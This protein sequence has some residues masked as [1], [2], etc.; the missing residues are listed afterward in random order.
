[1]RLPRIVFF[2]FLLVL[3]AWAAQP[4]VL[5]LEQALA[6][7][8]GVNSNVLLSREAAAQAL[9]QANLARAGVLPNIALN[10][11]QRRSRNLNILSTTGALSETRPSNRFDGRLA[12]TLSLLNP[13]QLSAGQAARV[14]AEGAR[15]DVRVTVQNALAGIASAYFGHLRN[16]R[17]LDVLDANITRARSLYDLARNQLAAGV[18]TQ[19]DVTRAESQLAQAEQA[20]LQQVT[21]VMQSELVFKRLLNLDPAAPLQLAD[22][23]LA[24]VDA[25]LVSLGDVRTTFEQRADWLRGQKALEQA[26]LDVRTATFERLPV[27]GIAGDYGRAAANFDDDGKRA[28][29]TFGATLSVPIFDGLRAGADHRTALS[30]QR[31]QQARLNSLELQISS[32]LRLARQDASSRHAQIAVAEKNSRLADEQLRL[33]RA[34]Y[35]E[36]VA[37]NR[38]VI[39]A[40]TQLAVAADNLVDAVYQYNLSRVELAR[41]KGEVRS[42]LMEKAP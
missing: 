11:S 41:V 32:E 27:L 9:E 14:G 4:I 42:V 37:D 5:T 15:V 17:R 29:W 19:I 35:N 2:H 36:G 31:V 40:Q 6:S 39:E 18:A 22:F 34:R 30:R 12:G 25:G 26:R 13:Q 16:L 23:P 10:V 20:R 38:E 3:P 8:E 33:A 7:A 1:M 28:V 21:S 24:R